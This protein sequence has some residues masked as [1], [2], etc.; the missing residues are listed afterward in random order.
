MKKLKNGFT[1]IE[2]LIVLILFTGFIFIF[3]QMD[4]SIDEKQNKRK[5]GN[6]LNQ[7]ITAIDKRVSIEGKELANWNSTEW[8]GLEV[9]KFFR[10]ELVGA[11]NPTCGQAD[12]WKPE[13]DLKGI[14]PNSSEGQEL[15]YLLEQAKTTKLLPCSF[16]AIYPNKIRPNFKI[17]GDGNGNIS[18]FI[19]LFKF[20]NI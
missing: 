19:L 17:L 5:V 9:K 20:D 4:M 14:D 13:L 2:V 3:L 15:N 10:E 8:D 12:G 6:Q 16:W 7:I 18:N 11:Q 1:L